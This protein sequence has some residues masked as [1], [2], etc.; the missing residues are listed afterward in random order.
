MPTMNDLLNQ[1]SARHEHLCPR[2]VLGVRLGMLA[3]QKLKLE[4]PQTD[5]RVLTIVETDG[6]FADGVEVATG[7]SVGHRTLRVEDY[8]KV[9]ATL[10]D[11]LTGQTIRIAPRG[12]ARSAAREYAPTARNRWEAQLIGY[13]RMPID[14]LFTIEEVRLN[15]PIETIVSH[16][17]RKAVCA[18]CGE[19]IINGRE[20]VSEG[21]VWCKACWVG[22]YYTSSQ[23]EL[24][25]VEQLF[26]L[27]FVGE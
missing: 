27:G 9:A 26:E 19:E 18:Q 21:K 23:A 20:I 1:S 14:E 22:A 24:S 11:T 12:E 10:V 15:T 8:G 5:K 2:Q 4:L 16:A 25:S 13:Q 7:C 17:G 6:C 3:A